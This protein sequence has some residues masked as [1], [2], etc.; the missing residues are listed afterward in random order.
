MQGNILSGFPAILPSQVILPSGNV[1]PVSAVAVVNTSPQ[2]TFISAWGEQIIILPSCKGNNCRVL[3]RVLSVFK[4][5]CKN[6]SF[7]YSLYVSLQGISNEHPHHLS[8]NIRKH[9]VK[10][11][12]RED[13]DQ[14]A[15]LQSDQNLCVF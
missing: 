12:L 2:V 11:A 4:F 5:L 13:S 10:R 3:G 9:T 7:R 8:L 14:H 1:I 15:I 6:V